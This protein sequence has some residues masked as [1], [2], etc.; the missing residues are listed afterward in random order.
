MS[1][2]NKKTVDD[3]N[4]KGKKV[5][6]RCDFNVPMSDGV[7]TDDKRIREALKT[8][9]YLKEKVDAGCEFLTTQMFFDNNLLYNFLYLVLHQF[10]LY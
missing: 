4:A 9:K 3:I 2:L 10:L 7:I 6:V 1:L 8:I 5:L